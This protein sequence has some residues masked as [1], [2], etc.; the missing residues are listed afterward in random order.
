MLPHSGLCRTASALWWQYSD[1]RDDRPWIA[2]DI[3]A[4]LWSEDYAANRDP[5]VEAILRYV[6]G[7]ARAVGD[8]HEPGHFSRRPR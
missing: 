8:R 4:A 6:P 1:P 3:P 5:A 7:P 2:P